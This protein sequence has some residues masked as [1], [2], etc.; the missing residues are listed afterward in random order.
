MSR[1]EIQHPRKTLLCPCSSQTEIQSLLEIIWS[2]FSE[3]WNLLEILFLELGRN[4]PSRVPKKVVHG[5]VCH[6]RHSDTKL[7]EGGCGGG[8][9]GGSGR[10]LGTSGCYACALQELENEDAA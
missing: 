1:A 8:G 3:W 7:P 10:P 6:Q 5:E 4:P 9:G 2:W